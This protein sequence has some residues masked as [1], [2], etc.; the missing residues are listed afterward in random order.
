MALQFVR[1]V[2]KIVQVI[3]FAMGNAES[4]T[5]SVHQR[6]PSSIRYKNRESTATLPKPSKPDHHEIERRFNQVLVSMLVSS[7]SCCWPAVHSFTNVFTFQKLGQAEVLRGSLQ[8][9]PGCGT[10]ESETCGQ[11]VSGPRRENAAR[12]CTEPHQIW[13]ASKP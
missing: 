3:R 4:S 8:N 7:C 6:M 10:N 11:C 12:A 2:S 5:E 9:S 13:Q 1:I